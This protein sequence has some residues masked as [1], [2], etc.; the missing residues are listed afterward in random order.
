MQSI[1]SNGLWDLTSGRTFGR[2]VKESLIPADA[3]TAALWFVNRLWCRVVFSADF[4]LAAGVCPFLRALGTALVYSSLC[5]L[6]LRACRSRGRICTERRGNPGEEV[7]KNGQL[8]KW[9]RGWDT[10]A[11]S[12]WICRRGGNKPALLTRQYLK[13]NQPTNSFHH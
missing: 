2:I 3:Q 12:V 4:F 5:P 10:R 9:T 11:R 6:V 13:R 8:K 1:L 7:K